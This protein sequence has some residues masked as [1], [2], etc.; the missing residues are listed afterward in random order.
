MPLGVII[1]LYFG[2]NGGANVDHHWNV[3]NMSAHDAAFDH[4]LHSQLYV[5]SGR[6]PG[7]PKIPW[8][9]PDEELKVT[10][11]GEIA[12]VILSDAEASY[13]SMYPV[14]LLVGEQDFGATGPGVGSLLTRLL[15]ALH[16]GS[17]ERLLLQQY[18]VD[19][20]PDAGWAALN[21]TGK[22]TVLSVPTPSIAITDEDLHAIA[23][24][25]LPVVV[26]NTT[27]AAPTR[28]VSIL[29]QVS[30]ACSDLQFDGDL[31][32]N[33]CCCCCCR[34]RRRRRRRRCCCCV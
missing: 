27:L 1:D 20:M 24:T 7:Y 31:D 30:L 32:A 14:L 26:L 29:W 28:T 2:Y 5:A 8:G 23:P 15:T 9:G 6:S 13:L 4:L 21:A 33:S 18:H 17:C 16:S 34:R 11:H 12:D 25:Y 10:P 19:A 22:V 3:L